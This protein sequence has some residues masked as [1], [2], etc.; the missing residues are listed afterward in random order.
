MAL[1]QQVLIKT[2][3]LG[4]ESEIRSFN[5]REEM[6]LYI[7]EMKNIKLIQFIY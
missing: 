3:F 1:V 4:G 6:L 7:L 5:N 2:T